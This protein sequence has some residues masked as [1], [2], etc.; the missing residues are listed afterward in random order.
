M[1][2]G[3]RCRF[4]WSEVFDHVT[5]R[6]SDFAARRF[7]TEV[8]GGN[9]APRSS[10]NVRLTTPSSEFRASALD[11]AQ[12]VADDQKRDASL[13]QAP[14]SAHC[15]GGS[16]RA[17]GGPGE[18]SPCFFDDSGPSGGARDAGCSGLP[19]RDLLDHGAVQERI[20]PRAGTDATSDA[21]GTRLVDVVRRNKHD[22]RPLADL[23]RLR[24]GRDS[25]H[26][27]HCPLRLRHYR[28]ARRRSR[29]W[30]VRVPSGVRVTINPLLDSKE[31]GGF[32][33]VA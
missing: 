2:S 31:C 6:V 18:G 17:V 8:I 22:T 20:L 3:R 27:A 4:R 30:G 10:R 21:Y 23:R 24:R 25:E 28:A 7:Y 15:C 5:I 13:P 1:Q 14:R 29:R 26:E 19:Q 32:G 11:G 9:P 12:F 16:C 33:P